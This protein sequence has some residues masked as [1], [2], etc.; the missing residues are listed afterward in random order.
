MPIRRGAVSC[1]RFRIEGAVPKDTRKWLTRA[2]TKRAFEGIDPK[3][4]EDRASGFVELEDDR[5]TA[6]AGG[7]LF[8]GLYA[9][10]G[11]RVE[12]IR[13]PAATLRAD[14]AE[15]GR[16]FEA[17]NGRT[18]GRREKSEQKELMRKGLRAK[19]PPVTSVTDVSYELAQGEVLIWGSSTGILEEVQAALE[20]GLE[21]RLIPRVPAS[22][23]S[24][25]ILETLAP[26]PALFDVPK[27]T[28]R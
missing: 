6:F 8:N 15:W 23:V 9:L 21:V 4:D 14:L 24:A 13:I 25:K 17:K 16:K 11:W 26:T 22:H 1:S 12:K 20:S 19:T 10:F 5:A 27:E 7:T 28:T 18:P 2:L 3:G